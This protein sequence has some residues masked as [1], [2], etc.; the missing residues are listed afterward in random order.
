[1]A[2]REARATQTRRRTATQVRNAERILDAALEVFA[3]RGYSGATVDR[4]AAAAGMSKPNLLYYFSGKEA[5]HAALIDDLLE[6][7]LAPLRGLDPAGDPIAEL[8]GYLL[9]KLQ[10]ARD[11]PRES[12]LF[13]DEVL[14]GAPRIGATLAGSLRALVAEK[15]A[16]IQGWIDAGRLAPVDPTHLIFAIWATTQHYADFEAQIRAVLGEDAD[17][18]PAAARTLETLLLD[19]LRPRA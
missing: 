14:Q 5:I 8:R 13:A 3:A 11:R 6:A 4:I 9:R 12:R 10:M 16:I 15:A 18:F 7:W 2:R 1:M 17:P 19:G